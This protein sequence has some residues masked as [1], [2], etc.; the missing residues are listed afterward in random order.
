MDYESHAGSK[1]TE[2]RHS[3]EREDVTST[4]DHYELGTGIDR[5]FRAELEEHEAFLNYQSEQNT[6]EQQDTNEDDDPSLLTR[7]R[8]CIRS[9]VVE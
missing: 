4:G 2:C 1:L 6:E 3:C 9:I 5:D 8:N 7:L